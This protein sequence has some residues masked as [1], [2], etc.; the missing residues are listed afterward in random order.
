MALCIHK[1]FIAI[2]PQCWLNCWMKENEWIVSFL[3]IYNCY[4]IC[5]T[6]LL[7]I[8]NVNHIHNPHRNNLMIIYHC[9]NSRFVKNII[10]NS[11]HDKIGIS[12]W[13]VTEI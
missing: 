12:M 6:Y 4:N 9:K 7:D 2:K 1:T 8:L 13:N 11:P 10:F 3:A 5:N